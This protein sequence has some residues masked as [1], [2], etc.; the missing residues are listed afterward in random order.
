MRKLRTRKSANDAQ[1]NTQT[2][3][4]SVALNPAAVAVSELYAAT[5]HASNGFVDRS[6]G[7]ALCGSLKTEPKFRF[8]LVVHL[9]PRP[10]TAEKSTSVQHSR[11]HTGGSWTGQVDEIWIDFGRILTPEKPGAHLAVFRATS[12]K[13]PEKTH[14]CCKISADLA[15]KEA[16]WGLLDG[17]GRRN[18]HIFRHNSAFPVAQWR[19]KWTRNYSGITEPPKWT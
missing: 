12:E 3:R 5:L 15:F 17:S 14:F 2:Q 19:I 9:R 16:P 10:E 18:L 4:K 1:E 11:L 7:R 13:H 6:A 8:R